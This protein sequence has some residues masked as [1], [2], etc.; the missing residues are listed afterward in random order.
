MRKLLYSV[1]ESPCSVAEWSKVLWRSVYV[2]SPKGD[3]YINFLVSIP[4]ARVSKQ[5]GRGN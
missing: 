2:L 5:Q 3:I 4:P 1:R